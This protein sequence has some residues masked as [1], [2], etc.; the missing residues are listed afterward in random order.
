[1]DFKDLDTSLTLSL[2]NVNLY[3]NWLYN[4]RSKL[5]SLKESERSPYIKKSIGPSSGNPGAIITYIK[6]TGLADGDLLPSEMAALYASGRITFPEFCIVHLSK[7][8]LF[9]G[10]D[11]KANILVVIAKHV[12][13]KSLNKFFIKDI[14][15]LDE[16][17][18]PVVGDTTSNDRNDLF[19]SVLEGTGLF[20]H[21]GKVTDGEINVLPE[22]IQ[23]LSYIAGSTLTNCT[24]TLNS[25]QRFNFFAGV[26]GGVFDI[27]TPT[28]P[29]EWMNKF[30][31]L[32][33]SG[34]FCPGKCGD[35]ELQQIFYGAPGTGKSYKIKHITENE[36]VIRTT[37]HPDSDYS[38]FVGAYKPT[39]KQVALR[40]S[41]GAVVIEGGATVLE[42]RIVYE[43]VEQAFLQ[44]YVKA[45]IQFITG[46]NKGILKKQ[47]L[48]IEEINR[49]NCA[50]VFGDI[51]QLLDRNKAGFSAYPVTADH[52]IQDQLAREFKGLSI[53]CA[54]YINSMY[55]GR[56]VAS[57]I[58]T[59]ELLVLPSN[60]YIWATMN[61]SDQSL[62]PI[63]SAFKRRWEWQYIP[64]RK[65]KDD[66]GQEYDWFIELK[67]HIYDWW[68]FLV[69]INDEI[70]RTTYSEDKK[71][72]F[73]FC[74]A[75]DDAIS[76]NKFVS[77]V[78][79]Y[80]WNDV[81]KDF[82]FDNS[83]FKDEKGAQLSF[84]RFYTEDGDGKIVVDEKVLITF[85][86]NLKVDEFIIEKDIPSRYSYKFDG[87]GP[88][89]L[90]DI[91][92]MV[93]EKYIK[94]NPS[95]TA[96]EIRDTFVTACSGIGVAHVVE[97]ETEYNARKGQKSAERTV[98]EI[99]LANGD[100]VYV[101][102]QWRANNENANFSQ[103]ID[104][105]QR[106]GWGVISK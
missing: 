87:N 51:F 23:I 68:S 17:L 28:L 35:E 100:H 44:S 3:A 46:C 83:I 58:V 11:P 62:F 41:S 60:L 88:Y 31:H 42:D 59:G 7:E 77:K 56:D 78:I 91:A 16:A 106:N 89:S 96:Q 13:S 8:S 53:S 40:N 65:G 9:L 94:A 76:A 86:N 85:L 49:G 27:L 55:A 72:G 84:D 48:V 43:F 90:R 102:T 67:D 66:N 92:K 32:T 81:F 22:A 75:E 29:N 18:T 61:T 63:D 47:F 36:S 37:F 57:K 21:V 1:M 104:V 73:Y 93:V 30:P 98:S 24:L 19:I 6:K 105:V 15:P 74:K 25:K 64:I 54:T 45:W 5:L 99:T 80:L 71:L 52:D 70:A 20:E 14:R 2:Q 34:L 33:G 82:G 4:N 97:T 26:S 50:Q 39:T 95:K 103:F 79:F 69:K 12:V 10:D 38:T 101:S